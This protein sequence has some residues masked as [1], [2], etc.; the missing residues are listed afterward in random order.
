MFTLA[1][2]STFLGL[3]VEE[4]KKNWR[5]NTSAWNLLYINFVIIFPGRNVGK[6]IE[7]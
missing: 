1:S 5:D 4:Q 6:R 2:R 3:K 7:Q